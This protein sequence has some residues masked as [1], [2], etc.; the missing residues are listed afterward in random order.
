MNQQSA[1]PLGAA[2][3]KY[4]KYRRHTREDFQRDSSS[5]FPLVTLAKVDMLPRTTRRKP[6]PTG[7]HMVA[8]RQE[9][10]NKRNRFTAF[11]SVFMTRFLF[12]KNWRLPKTLNC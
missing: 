3:N 6:P 11:R 4:V 10:A 1:A 8:V 12:A 2:R 5:R 7:A 9:R